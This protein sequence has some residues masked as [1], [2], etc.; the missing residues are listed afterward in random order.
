MC[1]IRNRHEGMLADRACAVS[2]QTTLQWGL[3]ESYVDFLLPSTSIRAFRILR[4]FRHSH[5]SIAGDPGESACHPVRMQA[6]CKAASHLYKRTKETLTCLLQR[7]ESAFV[8]LLEP[9]LSIRPD[10]PPPSTP[11]SLPPIVPPPPS[12]SVHFPCTPPTSPPTR[13]RKGFVKS[14]P[15]KAS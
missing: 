8:R 2:V 12:P 4:H 11:S 10:F 3:G 14:K 15:T 9:I 6:S 5:C 13:P 1:W 7:G